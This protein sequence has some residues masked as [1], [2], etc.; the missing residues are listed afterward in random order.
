M[1][2]KTYT[3]DN[4]GFVGIETH[5]ATITAIPRRIISC[6]HCW[7]GPEDKTQMRISDY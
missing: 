1:N 7:Q 6:W 3:C 5:F 2:E 4:C